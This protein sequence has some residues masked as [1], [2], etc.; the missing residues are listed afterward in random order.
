LP[1]AGISTVTDPVELTGIND[2]VRVSIA[3]E[4]VDPV[5]ICVLRKGGTVT[6]WGYGAALGR[7]IPSASI[8]QP[9]FPPTDIRAFTGASAVVS[10]PKGGC[11]L[12]SNGKELQCWGYDV[13]AGLTD[14]PTRSYVAPHVV[15]I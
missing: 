2:A 12:R 3:S 10:T 7:Q 6:C 14:L 1:L 5:N 4:T 9:V 8:P 13:P 11:A 15:K